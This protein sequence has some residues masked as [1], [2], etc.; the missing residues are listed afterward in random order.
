M[1]LAFLDSSPEIVST[2]VK[3]RSY[4]F[5]A[6]KMK[7]NVLAGVLVSV[8]IYDLAN[9]NAAFLEMWPGMALWVRQ[10]W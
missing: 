1:I 3:S 6:W 7:F 2:R 9:Y 4:I 8:M 5:R 10:F